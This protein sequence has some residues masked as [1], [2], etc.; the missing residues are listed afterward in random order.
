MVKK[1]RSGCRGRFVAKRFV[2]STIALIECARDIVVVPCATSVILTSNIDQVVSRVVGIIASI[3]R[4]CT[5]VVVVG[6]FPQNVVPK[7]SV[8]K[9]W[10]TVVL[11]N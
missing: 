6:S 10:S 11:S 2:D 7:A 4:Q 9:S 1:P 5:C 3:I 8:A